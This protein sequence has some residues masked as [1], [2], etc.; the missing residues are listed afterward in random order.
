MYSHYLFFAYQDKKKK[1]KKN[2]KKKNDQEDDDFLNA[3]VKEQFSEGKGGAKI[4]TQP[5]KP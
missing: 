1:K 3:L 4:N 2:K 5:S